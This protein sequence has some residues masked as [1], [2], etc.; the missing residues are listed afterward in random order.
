MSNHGDEL[1]MFDLAAIG[2]TLFVFA[3]YHLHMYIIKPL[4][5]NGT[6][7][8]TIHLVNSEMWIR[9]HKDASDSQ[10][11]VLAIQTLRNTLTVGVFAGGN[12]I[13]IA[14]DFANDYKDLEGQ[15]WKVRSSILMIVLFC[16][17]ICWVNVIR[18]GSTL[19][20]LIGTM[21]YSEKLRTDALTEERRLSFVSDL[22]SET[23]SVVSASSTHKDVSTSK[24]RKS[25]KSSKSKAP[26]IERIASGDL[27]SDD[28]PNV[29]KE[30]SNMVQS[31]TMFFSLGFRLM[32]ISIPFAF[33]AAGPL[34]LVVSAGCLMLFLPFYDHVHR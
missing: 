25:N 10:T 24:K 3:A 34:A 29:F 12:A 23:G 18:L 26:T 2:V 8:F 19:G 20:Y 21:Q 32:F 27:T 28:I 14:T 30:A 16:S 5:F 33:Y 1:D 15:R 9:K 6:V 13:K 17:F 7:P 11:T 4:Y 22:D 31:M